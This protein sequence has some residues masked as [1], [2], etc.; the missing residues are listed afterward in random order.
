MFM[1][2]KLISA[3]LGPLPVCLGLLGVGLALLWFTRRQRAGKIV[4][5]VGFGLLFV[6]SYS[7]V[8]DLFVVPLENDFHPLMVPG[9]APDAADLRARDAR[10]IIVLGGG[11]SYDKRL[12]PNTELGQMTLARLAEGLR[13]KH[14]LPNAKLILSGGYG[15]V[16]NLH[17]EV[18]AAA[19]QTLGARPEDLVLEKRTFDTADEAR[20]IGEIVG[21]DPFIIV[22]SA[23]HLSRAVALFRKRGLDP[24]ASPTDFTASEDHDLSLDTFFP[25]SSSLGKLERAWHEYIGAVWSKLRGQT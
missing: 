4:T 12:P 13:L 17:S 2:K 7:V 10:W 22:S 6:L 21:K 1:L 23:S 24:L 19:A 20:F 16:G 9:V 5:S 18:L 14:Q 8:A 11:H 15:P 25:S 3:F